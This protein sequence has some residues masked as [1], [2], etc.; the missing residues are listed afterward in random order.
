MGLSYIHRTETESAIY[1]RTEL[2]QKQLTLAPYANDARFSEKAE[3]DDI[4]H[5]A[6]KKNSLFGV[7][8]KEENR[9]AV[10]MSLNLGVM[11]LFGVYN[12]NLIMITRVHELQGSLFPLKVGNKL[13]FDIELSNLANQ[14]LVDRQMQLCEV[15]GTVAANTIRKEFSGNAWVI[16]CELRRG[17]SQAIAGEHH[18]IEALGVST[19]DFGIWNLGTNSYVVPQESAIDFEHGSDYQKQVHAIEGYTLQFGN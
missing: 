10:S 16:R 17:N 11:P 5:T 7:G 1:A 9:Q 6:T 8:D 18:F 15:S 3:R 19:S 12:K 4:R 2:H 13:R 14:K